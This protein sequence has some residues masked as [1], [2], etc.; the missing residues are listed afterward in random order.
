MKKER[1]TFRIIE[2]ADDGV[3]FD[4]LVKDYLNPYC[5][6]PEI[7]KKH[8]ISRRRYYHYKEMI[9]E[10]TGVENKPSAH[11]GRI[12]GFEDT[13]NIYK[14]EL[15]GKF[16][17][18]KQINKK[19]YYFG[20]YDD[21]ETAVE[22]RKKLIK[23]NWDM[24]YYRKFIKPK[25]QPTF[26]TETPKGFEEDFLEMNVDDLRKKYNLSVHQFYMISTPLKQKLGLTR[27]PMVRVYD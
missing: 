25:Y 24:E 18:V 4:E 12:R 14:V 1:P 15:T 5:T 8:N 20:D 17:I 22:V 13:I 26:S 10:E 6:I 16:R 7:C 21:M 27:K 9:V 11:K 19:T 2:N 3:D 23:A